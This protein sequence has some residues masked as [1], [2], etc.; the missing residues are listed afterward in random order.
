MA[1]PRPA[2]DP[3]TVEDDRKLIEMTAAGIDKV[4]IACKLKRTAFGVNV[5]KLAQLKGQVRLDSTS[6]TSPNFSS[7][8]QRGMRHDDQAKPRKADSLPTG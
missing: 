4:V 8:R 6:R 2:R 7:S 5:S 3:W 1:G